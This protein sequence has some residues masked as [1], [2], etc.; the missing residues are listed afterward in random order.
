MAGVLDICARPGTLKRFLSDMEE[1]ESVQRRSVSRSTLIFTALFAVLQTSAGIAS[2]P[3]M[4]S[5]IPVQLRCE[6]GENPLGIDAPEP[7]LS[8]ILQS[9]ER[10][11]S[12]SAY[13]IIAASTP[14]LLSIDEGDL[15]D[16]GKT[17]SG[18]T[19]QI[20]YKGKTPASAQ[21]VFWKA[22]S[23]DEA[24]KP[25]AWSANA[26]WTTGLLHGADWQPAKWI[27]SPEMQG[28]AGLSGKAAPGLLLRRDVAVKKQLRRA[29]LNIS[30]LG[31]YM[32][33]VN[34]GKASDDLLQ[35]GW[36]NYKKTVLYQTYDITS[37]L[38]E[39]AMNAIGLSLAHGIYDITDAPDDRYVKFRQS[40]GPLQAIA[41]LRLE[42]ADA[43]TE[44]IGTD[45]SWQAA[46][47]PVTFENFFAGEDY[48][49]RLEAKGW[50]SPGFENGAWKDA[51]ATSGPGGA[52]R[53]L[54]CAAPPIRM[55]DVLAPV[56]VTTPKP[57]VIIYDFGQ[58]AS[59]MPRLAASGDAGAS[60]RIIPSELLGKNGLAD[61]ASCTQD[62][63]RPAWWQYTFKGG[64][65]ETWF[66]Q[67]FYQGARYLQVELIPAKKGGLLPTV[68]KIESVVIHSSSRPVG[69]FSCSSELFNR[70]Y[71]LVRWAQR[72][73]MMSVMT[74]CPHRERLPWLE[75]THL[76]GPS[77]RYNFEMA[78]LLAKMVDDMADSQL[79]NGFIPN[80]APEYFMAQPNI[81]DSFR[82]SPEWGSA[83]VIVPW[84][85]Y[86][87]TG[88]ASLLRRHYA[89]MKRYVAFLAA[90][91]KK[92]IVHT[93]LGDWYD[94]GPKPPWGSQL[95]P[96]ALTATAFYYY[97][98]WIL[99]RVAEL[100]DKPGDAREFINRAAEIRAAFNDEFFHADAGV[101]ATGS[102]TA[103]AIP[104]VMGLAPEDQGPRLLDAIVAD[105]RRRGNS[106]T[107]GDVGYRYLLRALAEG[108]RSDVI[109]DMN[110][111]SERPGYGMML[112]KGATSLTEKWDA[113][114]GKFG[115]QN[116]FMLGQINEWFFHDLAGIAPDPARPGFK[117]IIVRP[118][119]VGDITWAK[120]SYD[121]VRGKISSEWKRTGGRFQLA[122]VIPAG[123]TATVC[124]P[125]R[126]AD[127]VNES[128]VPASHAPGVK[129]LR[130][131]L[132]LAV[133]EVAS[134]HYDFSSTL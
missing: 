102:Q 80:I 96:P 14:E 56:K 16:S 50:D 34:G 84:Q 131:E 83:F 46:P 117:R 123:S 89:A 27:G 41:Q 45:E 36:T 5:L 122:V 111:Q 18:E 76:N 53:G 6:S 98:N 22:R 63:V 17:P 74:D 19:Y 134:G 38:K 31:I 72:S 68:E 112:K 37:L 23:W 30:G 44:I 13:Q 43:S 93:G 12:Q 116:H 124:M 1:E 78:P 70:T 88:D 51:A 32:L 3:Q 108:G 2:P 85:Q 7:G 110:S 77:L 101:Y 8:W 127:A 100:L 73:N 40:F 62:G 20:P 129:L 86:Q 115:S 52:L 121:S 91:S 35:P 113:G 92:N 107:S 132:G 57:G 4:A 49:A 106:L 64:G 114:V 47:S 97:D 61:R 10:G 75:Q 69:G 9:N 39:G 95:T 67:F 104:F 15:W 21:Q 24:D 87:F 126:R 42:Y 118:R 58:N 48:D 66:P 33:F 60:V 94:L 105:V 65:G 11:A 25:S 82:N 130:E 26:T 29:L 79:D 54:S 28:E 55:Q 71:A 109:F 90:T 120:A 133:F 119:P 125:A 81:T 99:A 103:N 59:M 128:G